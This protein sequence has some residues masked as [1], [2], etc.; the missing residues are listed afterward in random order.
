MNVTA[1]EID[2]LEEEVMEYARHKARDNFY[3]FVL[4]MAPLQ[5]PEGFIN[6][7]HIK[8]VCDA[9]QEL[10]ATPG[11]RLMVTLPPRSMKSVL[12]NVLFPAWV[13]GR[14][15]YWQVLSAA[16][17]SELAADFGRWV[18]NL[19][20]TIEYQK[21]FPATAIAQDRKASHRWGTTKGGI[22]NSAGVGTGIAGK[23]AHLGLVDD[24]LSEQTAF[25]P[26]GRKA[27][28][29]WWG[30]GFRSRL[31][32]GGRIAILSTRYG[33]DDMIGWLLSNARK[34]G[35]DQWKVI[36][37]PAIY[38]D[39][40]EPNERSYWPEFKDL[41]ELRSIRDDPSLSRMKWL[42]L[43]Q[44]N[45]TPEEGNIMKKEHFQ[46]WPET[47][48]FPKL[49]SILISCD[50][51]FTDK[52]HSDYS[53]LQAWG[54]F[55]STGVDSRGMEHRVT[56][57]LLMACRR[58]KWL[59]P[60]LLKQVK[61]IIKTYHPDRVV[62]EN[63]AS[64]IVLI[65]DLQLSGIPVHPYTPQKGQDKMSRVQA[66]LRFLDGKR[67]W[68]PAGKKWVQTLMEECLAFPNSKHDD[69]VDA[70]TLGIL[71]MRDIRALSAPQYSAELEED[72][73]VVSRKTYWS[74][75]KRAA[76]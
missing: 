33:E 18:K 39:G 29:D 8:I 19:I 12:G 2:R 3:V 74:R 32:P 65:Q 7:E 13:F 44:G 63:K 48:P 73:P 37:I 41:E 50:T 64:G 31:M 10:E 22:Y 53:V 14:N 54:C 34:G 60:D 38:N 40:D 66:S 72:T 25:T 9:L 27:V 71:F 49:F 24:P 16:H 59:Y 52:E 28:Q 15:P 56:N 17:S 70:L 57:A 67:L 75:F 5:I 55:E 62:V 45:P 20:Q 47:K 61:E 35:V 51:A 68:V 46:E 26:A 76:S 43:Y 69:Q 36:N 42:A 21:I 11:G 6:G 4:L 1:E 58:G 30:P 23:G